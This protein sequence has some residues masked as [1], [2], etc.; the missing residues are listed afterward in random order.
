MIIH[1]TTA[2]YDKLSICYEKYDYACKV[3]DG[4]LD[5]P[6]FFPV[7]YEALD[8]DDWTQ[9]EVW[10]KANPNLGISVSIDYFRSACKEAQDIPAKENTFKRLHLNI[11][12]EQETR[13]LSMTKWDDC[14]G[15]FK[16]KDLI[17]KPCFGGFDLSKCHDITAF[18]MEFNIDNCPA[19]LTRFWIPRDNAHAREKKDKVPYSMWEKQGYIT[20]TD[21]DVI[22]YEWIIKDV[23]K[24]FE[25]FDVKSVAFDRHGFEAVRQRFINL[26]CEEDMFISHGQGFLAMTTSMESFETSVR[27]ATLIHNCNPVMTWMASN[28][29]VKD[30]GY[31]NIRPVKPEHK[32]AKKIDGIVSAVMARTLGLIDPGATTVFYENHGVRTIN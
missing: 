11:W 15:S 27:D 28:V 1:I 25:K 26:G 5:D 29:A 2:G 4:I 31:G 16:E 13:W 32:S 23:M 17:G 21:G 6:K 3:R 12:T 9:E 22:D 10:F 7:I 20:M 8:K 18:T 30:D 14:K 19:I 24:D